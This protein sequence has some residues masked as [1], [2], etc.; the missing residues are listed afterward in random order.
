MAAGGPSTRQ[1]PAVEY[2]TIAQMFLRPLTEPIAEP[3]VPHTP[4]RRLRDALEPIA[5]QGWW[6]R[7]VY[8]RY[9]ALGLAFFD[10]YVWGRAASLGSPPA[11]QVVSAFGVFEPAFLSSVYE[12][13]RAAADRD[14]I[15]AAR[16]DGATAS[17]RRILG[18]DPGTVHEV[19]AVADLLLRALSR[20]DGTARPL[21]SGLRALPLPSD[22]H[23]RLW[24]AAELVREHRGDGHLAACITTGLTP[25]TMTILT[26]LWLGYPA[27][28]YLGSRGYGAEPLAEGLAELGRRG[29]VADAQLTDEGRRV[30][31]AIEVATDSS[32]SQLVAALGER[33]DDLVGTVAGWAEL[34]VTG[35]AF[36]TDPRKRAAG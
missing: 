1:T 6:S 21:F 32:Q 12:N 18:T 34:V 29:L 17:L 4:A 16:A 8:D 13:G 31:I 33:I 5:T 24:R 7:E 28:M 19:A 9:T 22:A 2:D 25:V 23:G 10:G 30:R 27:G 26:E 14:D 15:L 35:G 11:E 36:P 3:E 20:L